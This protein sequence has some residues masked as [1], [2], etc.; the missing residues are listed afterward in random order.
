MTSLSVLALIAIVVGW[1]IQ[2]I[3]TT[4]KKHEFN[5]LFL[6]FYALGSGIIAWDSFQS[7]SLTVALLNLGSFVL[8]IAILLRISK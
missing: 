6:I 1:L 7:G 8:P 5:P 3:S 2:L 4:P